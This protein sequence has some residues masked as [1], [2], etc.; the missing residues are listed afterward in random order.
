RDQR[1]DTGRQRADDE[2]GQP[3]QGRRSGDGRQSHDERLDG[4]YQDEGGAKAEP[5]ADEA[6]GERAGDR[7]ETEEKPVESARSRAETQVA[8]DEIDPE[9]GM[10]HEPRPVGAERADEAEQRQAEPPGRAAYPRHRGIAAR[11]V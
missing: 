5:I 8:S 2:R 7:A 10:R 6:R 4:E 11:Q 1:R 9:D 3:E